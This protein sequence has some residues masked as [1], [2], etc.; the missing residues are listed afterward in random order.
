MWRS[1][2]IRCPW[3]FIGQNECRAL[4][5]VQVQPQQARA[6]D[7]FD[8]FSSM[9]ISQPQ[10]VQ[11]QPSFYGAAQ[12]QQVQQQPSFYGAAQ[13]NYGS[14]QPNFG[15]AQPNYGAAQPNYGAVAFQQGPP[16]AYGA[17]AFSAP[18]TVHS[19]PTNANNPFY[20]GGI[21]PNPAGSYR[22]AS[23]SVPTTPAF[24]TAGGSGTPTGH[25]NG[26]AANL[27]GDP[28]GDLLV[29]AGS[30]SLAGST[31]KPIVFAEHQQQQ[32]GGSKTLQ[33]IARESMYGGPAQQPQNQQG[34]FF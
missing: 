16:T 5:T 7:P 22:P 8:N 14:A 29:R 23:V 32:V 20:A 2:I 4:P 3:F 10:Q 1:S 6:G 33:Q 9:R 17:T 25:A 11:Q 19:S 26:G 31:G 34:P 13:P 12:P 15:A 24:P 30:P 18:T 28:F 27:L 21:S